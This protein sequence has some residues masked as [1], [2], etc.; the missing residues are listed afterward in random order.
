MRP[1]Q[2]LSASMLMLTGWAISVGAARADTV[3]YD[4]PS[5]VQGQ[6]GFVQSLDITTP[7][8]LTMAVSNIPWLDVVTDMT[9]FLSSTTGVV[10]TT[11]DGAG[12]ES[13]SVGPGMYYA[14]WFGDAQGRYDAGVLGVRIEFRPYWE[15]V[16]I[17]A[18]LLLMPT[19]PE[20]CDNIGVCANAGIAMKS[21]R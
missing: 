4:D 5:V 11:M 21:K 1:S 3:L 16:P 18:S 14:H 6:Q 8:T 20:D 15:P 17:P 12:S 19:F 2:F 7:G 9:S 13:I 10:G